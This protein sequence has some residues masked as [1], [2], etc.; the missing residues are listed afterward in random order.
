MS[1][2]FI[3]PIN[4]QSLCVSSLSAYESSLIYLEQSF[5]SYINPVPDWMTLKLLFTLRT[6]WQTSQKWLSYWN[7]WKSTLIDVSRDARLT[8]LLQ[9]RFQG[10]LQ[11]IVSTCLISFWSTSRMQ[12]I[13][14]NGI[15]RSWN[16]DDRIRCCNLNKNYYIVRNAGCARSRYTLK[17]SLIFLFNQ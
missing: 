7:F 16:A 2:S 8:C 1:A 4:R 3:Q 9:G 13:K 14:E 11:G 15:R 5:Y 12:R 10:L 17:L 6:N